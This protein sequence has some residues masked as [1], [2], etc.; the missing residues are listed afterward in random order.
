MT[1]PSGRP[2]QSGRRKRRGARAAAF[3]LAS[4]ALIATAGGVE[5][6]LVQLDPFAHATAG[7]TGC[8]ESPP[9]LVTPERMRIIAHERAERGTWCALEGRCEPGG[10]Y[11]RDP[12]VNEQVRSAIAADKRFADTAIWVT[13]SRKFVTLAGC[14]RSRAQQRALAALVKRQPMV[15]RVFDETRIGV[16]KPGPAG[17]G[18]R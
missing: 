7:F 14:V 12:E 6:E 4:L 1:P 16:A 9:P 10:A 17:R 18:P 8:P 11:R 3:A 2:A 13:T 15:D 5:P